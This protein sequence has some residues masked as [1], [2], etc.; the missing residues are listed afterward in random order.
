MNGGSCGES[1]HRGAIKR[2]IRRDAERI[3]RDGRF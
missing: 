2:G 1:L 3:C